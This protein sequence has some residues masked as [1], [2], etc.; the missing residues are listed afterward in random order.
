MSNTPFNSPP[1]SAGTTEGRGG[2]RLAA[3]HILVAVQ[4][5]WREKFAPAFGQR[6]ATG[7]LLRYCLAALITTGAMAVKETLT[8]LVGAGLPP[9][10]MFYPAVMTVALV[11]GFRYGLA[12]TAI[13]GLISAYRYLPPTGQF[14]IASAADRLGLVIFIGMGLFL[15]SISELYRRNRRKAAAFELAAAGHEAQAR[16]EEAR[17]ESEVRYRNLFNTMD[18]GF[19]IIEMIFDSENRPVDYR[20]LEI[21]AAFER[22]TGLHD[23]AGKL[24][25]EL[26]PNHE[27]HWFE[28]YGKIA[29][30]GEPLHFI[31]EAA[32]LNR[33]YEVHAYRVDRPE[34]RHVAILFNDI[35]EYKRAEKALSKAH[36]EMELRVYERTRE[37]EEAEASL[38]EAN[39]SLERRVEERTAELRES[40]NLLLDSR[41]AALNLME[42]A[43]SARR[44]A[45][46]TSARLRRSKARL[47]RFY[48]SGLVGIIYWN[49]SGAISD[50]NDKF[51]KMVG[52]TR[53]DLLSGTVDWLRM[54]P[55]EYFHLDEMA[56]A[57]LNESGVNKPFEKEYI[58][59]DGT[60]VPIIAAAAMLDEER[61]NG[62]AIVLDI[63]E[64][65][66]AEES[67]RQSVR[68]FRLLSHTAEELLQAQ[69]PQETVESLCREVME[70]LDCHAFFN[71]LVD[72][73]ADRLHLNAC[74]GI[75]EEE[76]K[77][78]EWLDYGVAVCGCA[79]RDAC[80]IVAERIPSTPDPRTELVKSYGIRAYACHPLLGKGGAVIG[81]LSFGTRSRETF[82]E[83]DLSLMKAVSDQVA[84]AMIR[85]RNEKQLE[86]MLGEKETLLKELYHRTKNNMGVISGLISLQTADLAEGAEMQ[87]FRELQ[88][89][90]KSMSL[91]HE[92]LYKSKDLSNV[93]LRDYLTDLTGALLTSYRISN[94]KVSLKLDI[95]GCV[96]SID[97]ITPLGLAINEL[98]TNSLKY[99]FPGDRSGEISLEGRAT[100]DGEIRLVYK[101]NGIG[102]PAGFDF[103]GAHTLGLKLVNRLIRKQLK[104]TIDMGPKP[105][106][107]FTITF[108][109]PHYRGRI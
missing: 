72:E 25:R 93:V 69:D 30:T 17:R 20:F 34:D 21:N 104:G 52:Y 105:E 45:E 61:F 87:M 57:Q 14:F 78:I 81:T 40:N 63:T 76:A 10:I 83:E 101:D 109:E 43:L 35:S 97:S 37:L 98:V 107:V 60:R 31:N 54:T 65:K 38:K 91:V 41:R 47:R 44:Q 12:S 18:E 3:L 84:A 13:A 100:E 99:A 33:W 75:P 71:F 51:L 94:D 80:R 2:N 1:E 4:E 90:I 103:A 39:D 89:R 59:K 11:S 29:V 62:V 19:C 64:R 106:T 96:L 82:S 95:D 5:V 8:A 42:D 102:F 70:K 36:D 86:K 46:E 22:Q 92:R 77:K 28:L 50:A 15:S 7:S 24:M 85:R 56:V 68:R 9:Y 16:L 66:E 26:A 79:A 6:S 23:A 27:A 67:L 73:E 49:M 55:P 108:R 32:A 88:N 58:R 53:E 74:S 48:E